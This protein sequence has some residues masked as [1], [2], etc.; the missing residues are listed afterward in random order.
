MGYQHLTLR[1]LKSPFYMISANGVFKWQK[2]TNKI[3]NTNELLFKH[4]HWY[5][6]LLH[7]ISFMHWRTGQGNLFMPWRPNIVNILID[8]F[9]IYSKNQFHP[10]V[11][12]T[13]LRKYSLK[14]VCYAKHAYDRVHH[15][16]WR[17]NCFTFSPDADVW[18]SRLM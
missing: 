12:S 17:P 1:P 14:R 6:Y 18:T 16:S 9:W 4:F 3:L 7:F 8:R 10:Y 13:S 15:F 5:F 2:C 11:K